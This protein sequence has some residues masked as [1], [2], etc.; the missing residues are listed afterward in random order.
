MAEV[1]GRASLLLITIL[2]AAAG[3]PALDAS[4]ATLF[5]DPV[6]GGRTA[7]HGGHLSPGA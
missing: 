6:M 7:E 5:P 4:V 2:M 1:A 3:K